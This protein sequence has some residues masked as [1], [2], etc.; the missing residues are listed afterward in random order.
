[1]VN[2]VC[3]RLVA[4]EHRVYKT[5]RQHPLYEL[6]LSSMEV[7]EPTSRTSSRSS[8]RRSP[9]PPPSSQ[10]I[11]LNRPLGAGIGGGGGHSNPF[12]TLP[13]GTG[14][15]SA[16]QGYQRDY[17]CPPPSKNTFGSRR[18]SSGIFI[19][20]MFGSRFR[21]LQVSRVAEPF[22]A[23][24]TISNRTTASASPCVTETTHGRVRHGLERRVLPGL[25]AGHNV[26]VFVAGDA[27][28]H[29]NPPRT[30]A[31]VHRTSVARTI[32]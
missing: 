24:C 3:G 28:L 9:M 4:A 27:G 32:V 11:T 20:S 23:A 30:A 25:A 15:N 5:K 22:L 29:A 18:S 21:H 10:G 6:Y 16:Y 2:C 12:A 7:D 14:L 19:T 13:R 26:Q 17:S 31:S 8:S 1:M